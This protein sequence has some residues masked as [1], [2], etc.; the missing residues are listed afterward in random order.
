VLV[1]RP[2]RKCRQVGVITLD[3]V[4]VKPADYRERVAF[5]QQHDAIA[6]LV[7]VREAIAF[8]VILR[9]HNTTKDKRQKRIDVVLAALGLEHCADVY[10]GNSDLIKG[11]SGGERRRTSIAIEL[12]AAP[13]MITL[14]E[15]TSGLDSESAF[16]C[17]SVLQQLGRAGALILMTIHQPT[18]STFT[19][20]DRVILM[21]RG[22]VVYRGDTDDIV[23]DFERCGYECPQHFNIADYILEVVVSLDEGALEKSGFYAEP[24]VR[25]SDGR[26]ADS[27]LTTSSSK[28]KK[29]KKG[30]TVRGGL[31][32]GTELW[33]LLRRE[34]YLVSRD[35]SSLVSRLV[36]NSFIFT[37]TGLSYRGNGHRD[38][39][40]ELALQTQFGALTLISIASLAA[41]AT[42]V[43]LNTAGQRPM[44]LNE[45]R[46]GTYSVPA[47]VTAKLLVE[48]VVLAV[49]VD[50]TLL[51]TSLLVTFRGSFLKLA[52]CTWLLGLAASST[53]FF[54]G[55]IAPDAKTAVE[56]YPMV[57]APQYLFSG[58]FVAIDD[59][60]PILRWARF[61]CAFK[62]ALNLAVLDEFQES[63]CRLESDDPDLAAWN[64]KNLKAANDV[65]QNNASRDIAVLISIFLVFRCLGALSLARSAQTA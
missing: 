53:A 46:A 6:P 59:M 49:Q 28:K 33:V 45:F 21:K 54:F 9:A 48:S 40:D 22:R 26:D 65:S 30:A 64:C 43:L 36:V 27:V 61:C 62:Y 8:S 55:A 25:A 41:V 24:V 1:G 34:A 31:S 20:I 13:S 35:T 7:T 15:P 18:S 4:D 51:I 50:V 14:D 37:L 23:R 58:F 3:G 29:K 52:T 19:L 57:F 16:E 42:A 63:N 39:A 60:P 47:F 12:V 17:I 32:L 10:V 44:F 2:Q 11:V 5:V 56:L 38:W